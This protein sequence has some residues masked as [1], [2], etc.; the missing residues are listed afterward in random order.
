MM[1]D[2]LQMCCFVFTDRL[3]RFT[4]F[5]LMIV[6]RRDSLGIKQDR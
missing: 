4:S 5:R 2:V 1:R 3:D 6:I